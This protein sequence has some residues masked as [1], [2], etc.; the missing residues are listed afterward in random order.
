MVSQSVDDR[1]RKFR[2]LAGYTHQGHVEEPSRLIKILLPLLEFSVSRLILIL[3]HIRESNHCAT[4]ER[5]ARTY[6]V[7]HPDE[8]DQEKKQRKSANIGHRPVRPGQIAKMFESVP[9]S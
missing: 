4:Q 8:A 6:Q 1:R 9:H 3:G 5:P 7:R 2:R